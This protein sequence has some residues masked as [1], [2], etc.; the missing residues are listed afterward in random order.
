MCLWSDGGG[1]ENRW[2]RPRRTC[3]AGANDRVRRKSTGETSLR[4]WIA[5]GV[6][7]SAVYNTC[8]RY[9]WKY[10]FAFKEGSYT[11]V[12]PEVLRLLPLANEQVCRVERFADG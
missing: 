2:I 12:F 11:A 1:C 9:E 10:I 4:I 6:A 3:S 8:Q 7:D 5:R